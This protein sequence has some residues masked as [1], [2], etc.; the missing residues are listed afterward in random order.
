MK[1]LIIEDEKLAAERLES[2]LR[3][4]NPEI[5]VVAKLSSVKE[6]VNWLLQNNADLIFI[7][8]QLSDG[9]SFTIFERVPV[10]TPVIFTTAYDQYAIKAFKFNSIDYL[11]KPIRRQDLFDS[12]LKFKN[13]KSA[14]GIDYGN[15]LAQIQDRKPEYRK[16]F[17]IQIG[18][19]IRKIEIEEVAYFYVF[20]KCCFIR[21]VAGG[22]YPVEYTLDKLEAIINPADFFR[23]N[24]KYIVQ[25]NAIA[26]MIAWS[27][28]RVKLELKPASENEF[29]TIVSIDRSADFKRW[30]NS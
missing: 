24:R 16:R 30:L 11:L 14:L 28:G 6:S 12:L 19:K 5:Q 15:L 29:D 17:L 27:R 4:I 18:E 10:S 23:I 20:D 7:D 21:T 25:M 22:H 2:M 9:I 1:V 3:E 13:L 26:N 8:I